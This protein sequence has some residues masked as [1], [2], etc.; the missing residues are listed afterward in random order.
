MSRKSYQVKNKE[1]EGLFAKWGRCLTVW[2]ARKKEERK[3]TGERYLK[4]KKRLEVSENVGCEDWK[5][6]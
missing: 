4:E 5:G 2:N 3:P 6:A 1:M